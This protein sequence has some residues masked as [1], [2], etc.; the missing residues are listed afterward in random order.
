[1]S[2]FLPPTAHLER[3]L[4]LRDPRRGSHLLE[5]V[6]DPDVATTFS[7]GAIG[8]T[9]VD[10]VTTFHVSAGDTVRTANEVADTVQNGGSGQRL[11]VPTRPGAR[12][13]TAASGGGAWP[14]ARPRRRRRRIR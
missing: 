7:A 3:H 4:R 9:G 1:M 12:P 5:A 13:V 10:V 11:P 8:A 6:R 2:L 14:A